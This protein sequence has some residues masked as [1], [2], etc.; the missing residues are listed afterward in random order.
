M[1]GAV[2]ADQKNWRWIFWLLAIL[3]GFCLAA[4]FLSLPETARRIVGN[5]STAV[6]GI[7]RTPINK[8]FRDSSLG[9]V[10]QV[11]GVPEP[12]K[13]QNPL[14]TLSLLLKKDIAIVTVSIGILYTTI[15]CLQASLATLLMELY[16]YGQLEAGLVYLPFGVG[17]ALAAYFTGE[18]LS[19]LQSPWH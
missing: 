11:S 4:I 9:G 8:L 15:S 17:C 1:I 10:E 2:L 12:A 14:A 7:R 5:G 13:I 3:S 6:E 16:G 18:L 19:A